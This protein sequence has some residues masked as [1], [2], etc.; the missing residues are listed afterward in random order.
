M[1]ITMQTSKAKRYGSVGSIYKTTGWRDSQAQFEINLGKYARK[2]PKAHFGV[3][4]ALR[5]MKNVLCTYYYN[6]LLSNGKQNF[7]L[8]AFTK[9]EP[10]TKDEIVSFIDTAL[11]GRGKEEP[12]S[13]D[14]CK[15]MTAFYNASGISS[16]ASNQ[17][18]NFKNIMQKI[19]TSN[20]RRS[21]NLIKSLHLNK[22]AVGESIKHNSKNIFKA[23]LS[24]GLHNIF[25]GPDVYDNYGMDFKSYDKYDR[26]LKVKYNMDK[27]KEPTSENKLENTNDTV[28][29]DIKGSISPN[30]FR[31]TANGSS[32][33]TTKLL[34]TAKWLGLS[35]ED[36]LNFRLAI[37]GW[38]LPDGD[39]SLYEILYS[40]HAAGV[41][42]KEDLTDA[43][44]MDKT[45]DPLAEDEI[46]DGGGIA[47]DT[48]FEKQAIY[49]EMEKRR[50]RI[51]TTQ[52]YQL[53]EK[54]NFYH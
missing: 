37:M 53:R 13:G 15:K 16:D 33:T 11:Y 7:Y 3:N 38:L 39:H 6:Q 19:V 18:I 48:Y 22:S 51:I 24:S 17:S 52:L 14:L 40:S 54:T 31:L 50:M 41:R 25:K 43:A 5:Q 44:S 36:L 27:K 46:R 8:Q 45:I 35:R 4:T 28:P 23:G 21:D 2:C 34:N 32:S 30:G 49:L 47:T 29:E 26:G 42:G 10:S 1:V 20:S 12:L 9:N